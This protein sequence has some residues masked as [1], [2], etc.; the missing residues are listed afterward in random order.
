MSRQEEVPGGRST[1]GIPGVSTFG[2]NKHYSD[3]YGVV[4]TYNPLLECSRLVSL[5]SPSLVIYFGKANFDDRSQQCL[6][7][8]KAILIP[9]RERKLES[10]DLA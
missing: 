10:S 3:Y 6:V 5:I 4:L 8:S 7:F 2:I 9:E 1:T